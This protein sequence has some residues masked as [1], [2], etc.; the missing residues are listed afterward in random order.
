MSINKHHADKHFAFTG[1]TLRFEGVTL[2]RIQATRDV[3]KHGVRAGELGGWIESEYNLGGNAW[4]HDQAKVYGS[5]RVLDD[6]RVRGNAQVGD[7]A[8]VSG[9]AEV[10]D[11]G[12][13][14]GRAVLSAN[15]WVYGNARISGNAEI[16]GEAE[17]FDHARV[18]GH[19]QVFASAEV[20]GKA[21]VSDHSWV[22]D[23]AEVY[24]NAHISGRSW[25]YGNAKVHGEASV[26]G[27]TYI[28]D[29]M[30]IADH[31]ELHSAH[32]IM[33]ASGFGPT[34]SLVSVL[35]TAGGG[36]IITLG[37][38]KATTWQGDADDFTR[39]IQRQSRRWE[40]SDTQRQQWLDE[41]QELDRLIRA[42]IQTW[43]GV[44]AG[45]H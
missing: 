42:R 35:R 15:A 16:Y 34:N 29:S 32:H 41:Y 1:E 25:V 23:S 12:R 27:N 17:V 31:V 5:A 2:R 36:H 4:V 33:V 7:Q 39:E 37:S 21:H 9:S 43:A 24:G 38:S 30:N 8:N 13:V 14:F 44:L 40:C 19:A 28:R 6:A 26:E 20:Y 18:Y 3:D 45:T 22:F 11:N 10:S